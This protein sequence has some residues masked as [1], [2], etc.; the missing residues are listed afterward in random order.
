VLAGIASRRG[1]GP[2]RILDQLDEQYPRD[3]RQ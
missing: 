3:G 1:D 2:E